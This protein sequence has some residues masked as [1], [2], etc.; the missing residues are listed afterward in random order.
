MARKKMLMGCSTKK[1]SYTYQRLFAPYAT[2][3]V[4]HYKEIAGKQSNVS[5][6]I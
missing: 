3:K 4:G 2:T 6:G 1:A 5:V